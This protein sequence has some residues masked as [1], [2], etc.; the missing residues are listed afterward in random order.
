[1]N[2]STRLQLAGMIK[3]S[4]AYHHDP[5]VAAVDPLGFSALSAGGSRHAL[6]QGLAAAAGGVVGS[7]AAYPLLAVPKFRAIGTQIL[8][9]VRQTRGGAWLEKHL[10]T[11]GMDDLKQLLHDPAH[12]TAGITGTAGAMGATAYQANSFNQ[13]NPQGVR[14]IKQLRDFV[15]DRFKA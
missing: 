10:E 6:N 5:L 2:A 9:R 3:S 7:L 12:I 4:V 15:Q 14:Q 13:Q 8:N 11:S 1:M